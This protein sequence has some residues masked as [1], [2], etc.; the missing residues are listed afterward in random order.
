MEAEFLN[1]RITEMPTPV[2]KV[3]TSVGRLPL[4][5]VCDPGLTALEPHTVARALCPLGLLLA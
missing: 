4:F 5:P 2:F 3:L 1:Q